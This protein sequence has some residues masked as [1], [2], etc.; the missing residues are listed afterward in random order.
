MTAVMKAN[1]SAVDS[2]DWMDNETAL[3]MAAEMA[4]P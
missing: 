4:V 2:V 3:K 1:S